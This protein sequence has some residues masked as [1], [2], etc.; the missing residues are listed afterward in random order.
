K[1][2]TK[3][4]PKPAPPTQRI[5]LDEA[6]LEETFVKGSGPGGQKINKCRHNVQLKHIPTGIRVESQRFRNLDQNRRE[7]RKLLILKLDDLV[8][9][10]DSKRNRKIAKIK[11]NKARKR[12]KTAKKYGEKAGD[13]EMGSGNGEG[14]VVG[15]GVIVAAGMK[16]LRTPPRNGGSSNTSRLDAMARELEELEALE[17]LEQDDDGVWSEEDDVDDDDDGKEEEE[18]EEGDEDDNEDGGEDVKVGLQGVNG[19]SGE[20]PDDR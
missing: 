16:G 4:K 2:K 1:P 19:A 3:P 11:K 18:E 17:A 15:E 10:Q 8:N 5:T 20:S 7:A 6:D 9:G 14:V 12:Q 13:S